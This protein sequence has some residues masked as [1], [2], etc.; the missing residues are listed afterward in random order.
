MDL[1]AQLQAALG[2]AYA[3]ERELGGGGMSRVFLATETALDRAVVIKLLPPELVHAVSSERFRQEIRLA[4]RLHHPHIVALLAAGEADGLLYYTMPFVE[5]ESLRSRLAAS[6]ELPLREAVRLL[7]DVAA[8]LAYAHER[9]IVHRDIKPDNVLIADGEALVTDFGVAKALSAAVTEGESGL[10]S[11]GVALGTPAYM[12]PEQ[13][14][15]DPHVD[16]RADIYALGCLAYEM[17]TGQPPFVGRTAQALL[18]AHATETPELAERRR[19]GIPPELAALVMRCLAKRPADRPQNAGEILHGL[20]PSGTPSGGTAPTVPTRVHRRMRVPAAA[21]ALL[22]G[23]LVGGGALFAWRRGQS[24]MAD[25]APSLRV[26]VLPLESVGDSND[27]AFA[28]GMGEEILNRLARVSGLSVMARSSAQQYRSSGKTAAEFGRVLGAD[29]VLDGTVRWAPGP[30]GAKQVRITP[31]LIRVSDGIHVWG[32]PYEGVLA[33]VFRL[34]SDVAQR[35]AEALQ[36]NLRP[37]AAA[38]VRADPTSDVEAYRLYLLGRRGVQTR[39]EAGLTQA[40]DHFTQA[41]ARDSTFARAWA[42]LA[43]AY[44]Y[45]AYFAYE[46]LP[47]EEACRR[48][49][50]AALRAVALDS[51]LAEPHV[52]LGRVALDCDLNVRSA[53]R[54][55]QRAVQLE[56][57]SADAHGQYSYFLAMTTRGPEAVREAE[58]AVRLDPLNWTYRNFLG[59][60]LNVMGRDE[61]AIATWLAILTDSNNS[62]NIQREIPRNNAILTALWAGRSVADVAR[63]QRELNDTS[64]VV[65]LIAASRTDTA[66]RRQVLARL[67]RGELRFG[68]F[69]AA[70]YVRFGLPDSALAELER[71]LAVRDRSLVGIVGDTNFFPLRDNPRF[72][73]ILR[74]M[75]AIP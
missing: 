16:Q 23:L 70:T 35:V 46:A 40:V 32:E 43:D 38:A 1:R 55:L 53:E 8:A 11:L 27:R 26:A 75:G 44:R 31:E 30:G 6:G 37:G 17:L 7:R 12:S 45:I 72:Q 5:G 63:L 19:P 39:S 48:S 62:G 34:Q 50:T 74:A 54:E 58:A 33:D 49:K 2:G 47:R 51:A 14:A 4:A 57:G 21:L 67:N 18:A 66:A 56:P 69:A 3:L 28:D 73:T 71:L 20:E 25:T 65:R 13:A 24:G 41:V 36:G 15:A 68:L 9:G 61:E 10:T 52:S 64:T 59:M 22:L 29:Y 42:G 60:A